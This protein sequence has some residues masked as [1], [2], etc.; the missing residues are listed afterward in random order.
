MTI[1]ER[2]ESLKNE[3]FYKPQHEAP[4]DF[5]KKVLILIAITTIIFI[6]IMIIVF[7][8]TGNEMSTLTEKYF[9]AVVVELGGLFIKRMFDK[10]KLNHEDEMDGD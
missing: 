3:F 10:S 6:A 9:D 8:V 1:S 7:L 2:F 5:R 4:M